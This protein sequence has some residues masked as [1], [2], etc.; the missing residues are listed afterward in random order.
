[1]H[2][3]HYAALNIHQSILS[4]R[5]GHVPNFKELVVYPPVIGLAVGKKAVAYG[6]ESGTVSGEEVAQSCFRD[7]LGWTSKFSSLSYVRREKLTCRDSLLE[8]HAAWWS[9]D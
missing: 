6:P 7:D 4:Q 2:H 1:M 9:Q 3:G 8:L 5:A